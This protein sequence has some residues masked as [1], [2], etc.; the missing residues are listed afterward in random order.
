MYIDY[1]ANNSNGQRL[2]ELMARIQGIDAEFTRLRDL[3]SAIGTNELEGHPEFGVGAGDAANFNDSFLQIADAWATFYGDGA[4][5][6]VRE[7]VS[8]FAR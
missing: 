5:G 7:K 3:V 1:N 6:T 2:K 8:R 4:G